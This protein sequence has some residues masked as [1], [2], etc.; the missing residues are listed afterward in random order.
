M[1]RFNMIRK[2]L[3]PFLFLLLPFFGFAQALTGRDYTVGGSGSDFPTLADAISRINRDGISG[4][5]TL[6][7][8]ENQP[9]ASQIVIDQ[10]V[11]SSATNTLTIK[12][13]VGKTITIS[14]GQVWT[15]TSLIKLNGADYV[16]IDGSNTINGTTKN[17]T[18][19]STVA[20]DNN[21][22]SVIWIGSAS[23]SNGATY[24]TIKNTIILGSLNTPSN[25]N[26]TCLNGILSS[27]ASDITK[28]E[29]SPNSYN[30]ITN[31]TIS[32]VRNGIN[33][34]GNKNSTSKNLTISSND[35][36]G[37]GKEITLNGIII[38]NADSFSITKN[39][40]DNFLRSDNSTF[41]YGITIKGK[42]SNGSILQNKISNIKSVQSGS[43]GIYIDLDNSVTSNLTVANNFISSVYTSPYNNKDD[44]NNAG[45][46]IYI[47]NGK[48]INIY[49]NTVSLNMNQNV[50]SACLFIADGSV[51]DIRNNIFSNSQTSGTRFAIYTSTN[52]NAFSFIR[53]NNYVTSSGGKIGHMGSPNSDSST[54]TE[55][56]T[57]T[58]QDTG[59]LSAVPTF[60]SEL[61]LAAGNIIN[62]S[63]IGDST[64]SAITNDI[65]GDSRTKPYMGADEIFSCTSPS[66]TTQPAIPASTCSGNGTQSMTVA[67]SGTGL[68][69]QWRKGGINL[70][71]GTVIGG[72]TSATLTL[73]NPTTSDAGSYDI[74]ITGTCS[75]IVTS[76]P[77]TV[78]INSAPTITTQPTAPAA[79]C[80]GSGTQSMTVVASGTG[81]LTYQWKKDGTNVT[82][83]G[84]V[85][86]ATTATLILTNPT[87]AN[88]GS[89]TVQ[90]SGSCAP[91][92]TSTPVAVT[93]N[94]ATA[95]TTQPTAPAATCSGNGSQSMTV[96]ATGTGLT[97]QWRKDLT[98]ITN[99]GVI[100]GATSATLTLTNP[101]TSDAGSYDVVVTGTCASAVTSTARTVTVYTP[102]ITTTPKAKTCANRH[103]AYDTQGGKS[104][105]IWSVS[106][107]LN[108]DYKLIDK[109]TATDSYIVI[110]W[111]TTGSKTV[112]VNYTNTNGC[113][114]S[115]PGTYT[116]EIVMLD[117]GQVNGGK[118]ICP[119]ETLPPLTFNTYANRN[120]PYPDT[121]VIE[122]WQYSDGGNVNYI[123]IPGTRGK[124][125]Y[126]PTSISGSTRQYRVVVD[127]GTCS[128][129]S[130]YSAI[131]IDVTTAITAESL[132]G[133]SVCSGTASTPISVTAVGTPRAGQSSIEYQWYSSAQSN[134]S[135][136]TLING[137]TSNAY[138]PLSTTAGTL[139]YYC[140][141][142]GQCGTATSN[143]SGAFITNAKPTAPTATV[144]T[145]PT[146]SGT[147]GTITITATTG[148][149]YSINGTDYYN[150]TV[151]DSLDPNTYVVTAKN[152]SGCI[153]STGTSLKVNTPA[154]K[155]WTGAT[156]TD[157]NVAGNWSP[158]GIP[159]ATDCVIIPA[160]VAKNPVISDENLD[161]YAYTLTINDQASLLVKSST[162]LRVNSAVKVLFSA[163]TSGSL[164]FENKASLIQTDNTLNINSGKISYQRTTPGIRQA[165][166]TYWSTPVQGQTPAGISPLTDPTKIYYH[167]GS[168]WVAMSRTSV[169]TPGKG[170]II[171]GPENYSNTDRAT[172]TATFSGTPNNGTIN[173]ENLNAD[174][175][176]LVGNPYPSALDAEKFILANRDML[177]GTLYFWTHNTPVVLGGAYQYGSDDY[178]TY[179]LTGSVKVAEPAG[180]ANN[181]NN[182][183]RPSGQIGAGQ[184][185]FA[186]TKTP[187]SLVFTNTMRS[188]GKDN[189]Q[190]YKPGK[191]SKT[192]GLEKHRVWLNMTNTEGAFKQ[193]MV[194][195]IEGA[196]DAY[197]SLFDGTTIDANK[198][199]DFYSIN[200]SDK[201][202]IQGR[203]LPFKEADSIPLG[204]RTTIN[205]DFTISID[206]VDGNMTTQKIYLEDKTTSVI[207]DLTASNYTFTTVAGTFTD[208]FV[209]RYTNKT[210]GTGDFENI[211]NG[212]L[213]AVKDKTIKVSSVKENIKEITIFDING[214]QLYNKKK[215]GSTELSISNLQAANQVLL[216]KVTLENDYVVTKK[217]IF[218]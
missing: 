116:T 155:T 78:T 213:V 204:Y 133:Q 35:F 97:Y 51:L 1:P 210:L 206:E 100:S 164:F 112:S 208:R 163:S 167:S 88:Q 71:N 151:F 93:I 67:A 120:V 79:T 148:Y 189:G 190:F 196:T 22:E 157:W 14:G 154:Y 169:M 153:S 25:E 166:Y 38:D 80:S 115:T 76:N 86:G 177:K 41:I 84:V 49:Y 114:T 172:Y 183:A 102:T 138:T 110:E 158:S 179:N 144:T 98:P 33:I 83:G 185:F 10:I 87:T 39:T 62:E 156:S 129:Q 113:T 123:D 187:G 195:Y 16:I 85:A 184:A 69:Y 211:E 73:T 19:K 61:F 59:S 95:I 65:Q 8:N 217:I 104:N 4:A 47:S 32:A 103:I 109:G 150:Q 201:L 147:K 174:K 146:C 212:F 216:V 107:V 161:S 136:P 101:T 130:I 66:I 64:L 99:G 180:S 20:A 42:S 54:I 37:S 142:R 128:D 5:V 127:N 168:G 108:T 218:Q 198:Y 34:K 173:T 21:S 175:F 145:Q 117:Q 77:V 188:G 53:Y 57:S 13:N 170:Y 31:N 15:N 63:L 119:G 2:L 18:I 202:V 181:A 30:T 193:L 36:G 56:Q 192:T 55:W 89:Y 162:T 203:A 111:L 48:K 28:E 132:A 118:H 141:V 6:L 171:R 199:L 207:H 92:V 40:L 191:D 90:I 29:D 75:P 70:S 44:Y 96:V 143:A 176:Y 7:L 134:L 131:D 152:A 17:L 186:G 74:V 68:T 165:D 23:N 46:G 209:L 27:S 205:G 137:A 52:K 26:S 81:P 124:T 43:R 24:N 200:Q 106:G 178:A 160:G 182:Y 159:S 3:L 215:V 214:K 50:L 82:N 122:K 11:G 135:S 9:L 72:A 140:I 197:E 12:P 139:Y 105:Y 45:H 194:G 126:T 94:T 91:A 58:G 121:S 125:T 149:T 60:S